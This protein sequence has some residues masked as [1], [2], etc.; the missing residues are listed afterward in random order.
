MRLLLIIL[1]VL[2]SVGC[3][4][5][6]PAKSI[7]QYEVKSIKVPEVLLKPCLAS[8]PPA[9][10]DYIKA[11]EQE[12]ENLLTDY[13]IDLLKTISICNDQISNIRQN[14]EAQVK[15]LTGAK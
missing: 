5:Q 15:I 12:R 6:P 2:L 3:Q 7:I 11:T 13:T 10:D 9:I 4:N 8:E 1:F 14:Q